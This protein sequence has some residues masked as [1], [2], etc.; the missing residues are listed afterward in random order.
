MRSPLG[1]TPDGGYKGLTASGSVTWTLTKKWSVLGEVSKDVSVTANDISVD[2]LSS[3]L[4]LQYVM[5]DRLSFSTNAGAGKTRF[6][7]DASDGRH[8]EYFTW[9]AAMKYKMNEHLDS[10]VSYVYNQNW[11]TFSYSDFSRHS[12]TLTLSS[13]W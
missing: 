2:T 4:A 7:G 1:A 5:N 8:D 3:S 12:V 10:A 11:S 9:G 6:L 13:R